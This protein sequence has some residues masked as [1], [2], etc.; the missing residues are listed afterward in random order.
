MWLKER[1]GELTV[2]VSLHLV[3]SLTRL[4]CGHIENQGFCYETISTPNQLRMKAYN[5]VTF[6]TLL[7]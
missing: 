1:N 2:T 5:F 4:L 6:N 7:S 3:L